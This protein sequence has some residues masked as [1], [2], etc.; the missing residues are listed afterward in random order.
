[1]GT[2]D[3]EPLDPGE[4]GAAERLSEFLDTSRWGSAGYAEDRDFPARPATSRLS[5]HLRFGEISVHRVWEEAASI[6][7]S[8]E[9]TTDAEVFRKELLWR[10]FA[11]H[12]L[13]HLPNMAT[14]N[15]KEKFNNFP[16]AWPTDPE[17]RDVVE[18]WETGNTG[19][20]IVDAGMREL[21]E[22]GYMHNRVRMI[23]GSLLTKKLGVHWQG[24]EQWMWDTLVDADPAS[25]AFNWQ[26]VAGCGDDASPYFRIFNPETQ[27]KKFD[28]DGSYIRRWSDVGDPDYPAPIVDLKESRAEALAAY[29]LIK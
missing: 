18:A 17:V 3:P 7:L 11:W 14:E 4:R 15:V 23:V 22:T 12:R 13:Y 9:D 16:W 8:A 27:A 28:P 6:A 1:M 21:W 24:G 19:I 2:Q 25:N 5:P 10:D 20:P 26:W 29:E